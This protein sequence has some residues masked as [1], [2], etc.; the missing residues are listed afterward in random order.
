[1]PLLA[2]SSSS[3]AAS[4]SLS[5][6][7]AVTRSYLR[8]PA[9]CMVLSIS[10][11]IIWQLLLQSQQGRESFLPIWVKHFIKWDQIQE[12]I[13]LIHS[14]TFAMLLVGS[15]SQSYAYQRLTQGCRTGG[16]DHGTTL[17]TVRQLSG[18]PAFSSLSLATWPYKMAHKMEETKMDAYCC[19]CCCC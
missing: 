10:K 16:K 14:F 9:V 15:Y 19:C 2:A 5:F 18:A 4:Q 6:L 8:L 3:Q 7:L 17:D 1:M 11:L 12:M 13:Y